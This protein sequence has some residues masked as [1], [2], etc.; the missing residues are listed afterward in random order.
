MA[1]EIEMSQKEE[2][3]RQEASDKKQELD[4][5]EANRRIE[6][7]NGSEFPELRWA[8]TNFGD[9]NANYH[10]GTSPSPIASMLR[11]ALEHGGSMKH[12]KLAK[13]ERRK[14]VAALEVH[15]E[16]AIINH[17]RLH[18]TSDLSPFDCQAL[19]CRFSGPSNTLSEVVRTHAA[20]CTS[21]ATAIES[22]Q[23]RGGAERRAGSLDVKQFKWTKKG[24]ADYLL[25]MDLTF[26]QI[27]LLTMACEKNWQVPVR[28]KL[29]IARTAAVTQWPRDS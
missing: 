3:E 6:A 14:R 21:I 11:G 8:I 25:G 4:L 13:T 24:L 23:H 10:E 18:Q 22:E 20:H 27:A 15:L 1:E 7:A 2:Q 12:S 26:P 29:L 17:Q 28:Y 16:Q 9:M 19:Q 5:H